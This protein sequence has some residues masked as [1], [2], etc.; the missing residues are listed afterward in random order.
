MSKSI[1]LV[2]LFLG[3]LSAPAQKAYKGYV[4]FGVGPSFITDYK[5]V[6]NSL[7]TGLNINLINFSYSFNDRWG[8]TATWSGGAHINQASVRTSDP[9]GNPITVTSDYTGAYRLIMLGPVYSYFITEKS[10]L[11]LKLRFGQFYYQ[12]EFK[13]SS[14]VFNMETAQS[15]LTYSLGL[16][17]QYRFAKRWAALTNLDFTTA[18]INTIGG[19]ESISPIN[20]TAGIAFLF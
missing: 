1:L 13:A 8:I 2:I 16:T 9:N 7:G 6:N 5:F 17:Y 20:L 18:K 3:S 12:E 11:E 19:E 10:K 14:S 4:G 15:R